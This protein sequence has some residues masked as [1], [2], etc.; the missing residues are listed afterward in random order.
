[1]T[2][3]LKQ[4]HLLKGTREFEILDDSIFV[5][6]TAP[7][8]KERLTVSLTTLNPEPVVNTPYLVFHSRLNGEPLLSLF[9]DKPNTEEFN[10]FVGTLKRALEKYKV[11]PG[12]EANSSL[13]ELNGNVYHEPPDID[14]SDQFRLRGNAQAVDVARIEHAIQMLETY[15][16]SEDIKPFLAALEALKAEPQNASRLAEVVK[17]F[18]DLGITQGAVLTYA[19]YI[20]ILLSDN[21]Y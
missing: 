19:P 20:S 12:A 4:K 17:T 3:K 10:D 14:E 13:P 15:L 16:A 2:I 1:M 6:I 11:F 7:F 5:R 9:L 8:K 21:P 18:N